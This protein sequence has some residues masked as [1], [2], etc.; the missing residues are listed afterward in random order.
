MTIRN[1]AA[2][3]LAAGLVFAAAGSVAADPLDEA[4]AGDYPYLRA[5]FEHFH[6]N[7]ELSYLEVE[8]AK[9]YAAEL[10]EA[11]FAVTEEVGGTGVVGV[12]EN[13]AGPTVLIR[14]D[15]DALPV[16]EK[17]G[18]PYASKV[19]QTDRDGIEKPVMHAC[20]HDVHMVNVIG[21]ARRLAATKESWSGT[22]V[23][24][25]QPAEERGGGARAMLEDGLY[26]RFPRPDYVLGHHVFSRLPEGKVAFRGGL[27]LSSVD[28]VDVTVYGIGTHGAAPHNGKDPIVIASQIVLALQT[29]VSREL[30]PLEPGVVTV[31]SFQGGSK[32]NIISDRVELKLTV[33]A[34]SNAVRD[35]LL[36]GIERVAHG[37][38]RAAGLPDDKLPEM[39]VRPESSLV[40]RNDAKLTARLKP[41]LQERLGAQNVLEYEQRNMGGEDFSYLHSTEPPVPGFY[42][43]LGGTRKAAMAAEAKK[44]LPVPMNHSP[45]FKIDPEPSIKTGVEAMTTAALALLE[46]R[47]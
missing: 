30:S 42:F 15:M 25:G 18:L 5:L 4:I 40:T 45:Y 17:T 9:R 11:G 38:G 26:T 39:R 20:G 46:A 10:R 32:H 3:L 14:A 6:A 34:N 27:M 47:H 2:G 44:G 12:L 19:I 1:A 16:E 33:R 35:K 37:I 28:M 7:P 31:G 41:A 23:V 8:T 21:S 22:L 43:I 24:I 36:A 13:G 29:L